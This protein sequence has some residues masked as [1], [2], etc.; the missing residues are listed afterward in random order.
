MDASSVSW[1]T[2]RC[3]HHLDYSGESAWEQLERA[4]ELTQRV[5]PTAR[6][7]RVV[8]DPQWTWH[9]RLPDH[10]LW[11]VLDGQGTVEVAGRAYVARPGLVF[12]LR[13]GD[14]GR[15]T[16]DPRTPL[17]VVYVH[18]RLMNA[19]GRG[20][21][22]EL[23]P[24]RHVRLREGTHVPALL[25]R[26]A[27]LGAQPH[28]LAQ[29]RR[30]LCLQEALLEIYG[31]D[32]AGHGH[33]DGT[34]DVRLAR[35]V[36]RIEEAPERRW[37]LQ[38]AATLAGLSPAYF[39]RQFHEALDVSFRQYVLH[40]RLER[41]HHLLSETDMRVGEVARHLGYPDH[42]L[43]SRQYRA[44]HGHPPSQTGPLR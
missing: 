5:Q 34:L 6:A 27:R 10:D 9:A 19:P 23:L 18:Y 4:A 36:R 28:P 40:I 8:C 42:R 20:S 22:T 12:C 17:T 7:E 13:P 11:C 35:V 3:A 38:E 32:A 39:S 44:Y 2:R 41:A 1:D 29:W 43:F 14:E 37:T 31:D 30:R 26:V 15:A 24:S 16:H 33:A 21:L 25:T